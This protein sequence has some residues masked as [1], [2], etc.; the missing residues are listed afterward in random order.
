MAK[1]SGDEERPSSD[2]YPFF[3]D[4][5]ALQYKR[6]LTESFNFSPGVLLRK[7]LFE[8]VGWY[9]E[10][11]RYI[12]DLPFWLK[13]TSSGIK[14]TLLQKKWYCIGRDMTVPFLEKLNF[15]I[16]VFILA[17][18]SSGKNTYTRKSLG[19]ISPFGKRNG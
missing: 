15:I 11:Y 8:K 9:D 16:S 4:Q 14:I 13:C 12:E 1:I 19:I 5:P 2:K 17:C 18:S 7:E 10:R 3:N 6:L